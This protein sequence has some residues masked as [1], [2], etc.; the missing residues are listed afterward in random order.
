M[1]CAIVTPL[2]SGS[3]E[4]TGWLRSAAIFVVALLGKAGIHGLYLSL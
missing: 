2:V 3:A 4:T 1:D